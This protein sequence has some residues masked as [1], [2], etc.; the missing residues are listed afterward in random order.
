M[1][2][3]S[4]SDFDY[5]PGINLLPDDYVVGYR[6]FNKEYKTTIQDLTIELIKNLSLSVSPQVL[7]VSTAGKD[8]NSGKSEFNSFRTIKRA[9]AKALEISRDISAES[10]ALEQSIGAWGVAPRPVNIF[11]KAGDY[12]EDNPI[13]LPPSCTLIGDNLRAASILPKNR[14]YDI[15][16]VNNRCYV[17]GFTFRTHK[18]PS[19]AIAYPELNMVNGVN[20]PDYPNTRVTEATARCEEFYTLSGYPV[21]KNSPRDPY[22]LSLDFGTPIYDPARIAFLTRYFKDL[23]ST[24]FTDIENEGGVEFYNTDYYNAN[25]RRP[26]QLTS[27]YPQ[28]CSSITRSSSPGADD[29]G[30]GV[31]VD[32]A[33]V[34]GPTRS[35]VMDSFTQFNEGGK[36][37]HVKNNGYAQLVSTFTIC[38]TEGVRCDTGGTCSINTSNC[39]FG[40]SGLVALGRSPQATLVGILSTDITNLTDQIIV[41]NL[42]SALSA[43]QAFPYDYQPY[44]GQ[45]FDIVFDSGVE[46]VTASNSYAGFQILTASKIFPDSDGYFGCVIQLEENYTPANDDSLIAVGV[47]SIPKYSKVYFYIR[48][49]ITTSA[50]T[51][52]Y[53]GTGTSLLSAV[54]QKGGQTDTSTEA[55]YD[56]VGR[57]FFTS[58][59]QFG[60]FRI[61]KDL[62]IVQ[63]TGTIE[64]ETFD[65]SILQKTTP[66][67]IALGSN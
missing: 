15:I 2:F 38:C 40:L 47:N 27:P 29:A 48:S 24:F 46:T 5:V 63:S 62:T 41:Y 21:T 30:A 19:Y 39:S 9:C 17:W 13:Y 3:K 45:V 57:V 31:L 14:C 67:I 7:Y 55:V 33:K 23:N 66:L 4:F 6:E 1:P 59:N 42:G 52:E 26:Y 44:P 65:R 37:I 34:D 35:M 61:G 8:T 56:T 10:L 53:I 51:M 16:W 60:D 12:L 28:G 25:I 20:E 43:E 58:T 18:S 22:D 49:T 54:P 50:H 11:V 64:G 32:G 36:G